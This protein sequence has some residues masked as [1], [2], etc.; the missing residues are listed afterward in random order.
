MIDLSK[1]IDR[2]IGV[3][4]EVVVLHGGMGSRRDKT[5]LL[6]RLGTTTRP[7]TL[8]TG[9]KGRDDSFTLCA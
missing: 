5:Q 8:M 7:A 3:Y 1:P 9:K 6:W 4:F 2:H